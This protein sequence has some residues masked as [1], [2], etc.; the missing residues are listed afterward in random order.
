[1]SHT[2][3]RFWLLMWDTG[4]LT[5]LVNSVANC[6]AWYWVLVRGSASVGHAITRILMLGV[7]LARKLLL[8]WMWGE[9]MSHFAVCLA[10][11]W[12]LVCGSASVGHAITRILM[13]GVF[14]RTRVAAKMNVRQAHVSLCC[15]LGDLK[16][17][18]AEFTNKTSRKS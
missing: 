16:P 10:W 8:R 2:Q 12:V 6:L 7:F 14:F 11:Y 4:I 1:M 9:H 17:S 15:P 3:S 13:L 5:N 18:P